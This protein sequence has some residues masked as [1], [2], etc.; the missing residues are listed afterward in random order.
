MRAKLESN[1]IRICSC[2]TFI[3]GK[4]GTCKDCLSVKQSQYRGNIRND[5]IQAY[6][7]KCACC[8]EIKSQFLTIDHTNN[9]G[10]IERK[11]FKRNAVAILKKIQ[12]ENYPSS[13]QILCWNCN[14]ARHINGGTCPH[15]QK[16]KL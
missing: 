1:P 5:V 8:G 16:V 6:G 9:D 4:R 14:V 3:S 12:K 2:G 7:G 13:Y 11:L 10:N 15:K